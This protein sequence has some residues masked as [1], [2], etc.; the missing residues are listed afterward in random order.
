VSRS[1]RSV[2]VI[3]LLA[4]LAIVL[5]ACGSSSSSKGNDSST[6]KAAAPTDNSS[7][8][9]TVGAEQDAACADWVDQCAS[10]AEG[11]WMMAYQTMPRVFNYAKEA[12]GNWTEV[13]SPTMA[14]MP[15]ATTNAAGQQV[16][17]YTISPN[18]V[19]SDGQPISSEDFK[20]TWDQIAHGK[21]I[22]D[23]TGYDHI[24]SVDATNPKVA[25]VTFK[26]D[27]GSW[28]QLFSA[29]YGIFPS[30]ILE[31]KDRDAL[32]KNGYS[33][34][35]GPWFFKWDKGVSV[36]LTPNP[37][38]YGT[39]PTIK[40]V[41][42]K[43]LTDTAAEFQAFKS[44]EVSAIYPQPEPSAIASIK[45]GLE[46]SKSSYSADTGNVEAL[47][48]NNSKF[49]FDSVAVR[50]AIG[51]SIDRDAIVARLF[52][53]LGVTKA[54][55]TLNP[56]IV[57]KYA[58]NT[59]YSNYVL[60]LSK[61]N[62]LMQG[63]GWAKSGD[64]W[65]KGGKTAAFVIKSTAGNK[66]RE[67][68]EQILQEQFKA[69]GFKLTIQN[70]SADDLFG[71]VLAAGNYQMSLYAQTATSLNPGLCAIACSDNIPSKANQ[72][73]G[74]NWQRINIPTLDPLLKQVDST[75]VQSERITASKQADQIMAQDQV[76]LPLDPLPNISL[77]SDKISGPVG[78]NP[79]LSMFWNMNEWT[80]SG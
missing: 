72:F 55:Q 1:K 64:Y 47:W 16:V 43:I 20:Y 34:S 32:M 46:G 56:P 69:A 44:G 10:S 29:D 26:D 68:T 30:H 12:D 7:G 52:G 62:S 78:D 4:V 74:Q 60:N 59:A 80:V 57:S 9:L 41:I 15:V 51:Y 31:G 58:D 65:A 40:K 8:T 22:Y 49:P 18:A 45:G 75:F 13:P 63:D 6:T 42:F 2:S 21:N 79:L 35:G 27:F 66:R 3:A 5:A 39:K 25:V 28:T 14:S 23:P 48:L 19:W 53:D 50:Q 54:V 76:S 61:V 24:A 73:G 67:L 17:T 70:P 11:N 37:K 33:W 36:T 38:W 71:K 77:W